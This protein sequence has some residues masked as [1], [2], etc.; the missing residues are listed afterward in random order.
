[1]QLASDTLVRDHPADSEGK[2]ESHRCATR[3]VEKI[4]IDKLQVGRGVIRHGAPKRREIFSH[5]FEMTR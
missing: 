2:Q 5:S 3:A 1:V 4:K